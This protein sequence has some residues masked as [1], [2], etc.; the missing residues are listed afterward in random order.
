MYLKTAEQVQPCQQQKQSDEDNASQRN[1][2][3]SL[4]S[5]ADRKQIFSWQWHI[6]IV[7]HFY[8]QIHTVLKQS[9]PQVW[10]TD[11][12]LQI[13][14]YITLEMVQSCTQIS[15]RRLC[16]SAQC[17]LQEDKDNRS[18]KER[19]KII[20]NSLCSLLLYMFLEIEMKSL[21][22]KLHTREKGFVKNRCSIKSTIFFFTFNIS[23][24][25]ILCVS[26]RP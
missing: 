2:P 21:K 22:P 16:T 11:C 5:S 20:Q 8:E 24:Q 3:A 18:K 13:T 6:Y 17:G 25:D 9:V 10:G 14:H 7:T 23:H 4:C 1:P 19:R 15:F 12:P 26:L